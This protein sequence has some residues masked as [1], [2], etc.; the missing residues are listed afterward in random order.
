[1]SI[2]MMISSGHMADYLSTPFLGFTEIMGDIS[3][4]FHKGSGSRKES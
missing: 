3:K 1:M 4:Q 2:S